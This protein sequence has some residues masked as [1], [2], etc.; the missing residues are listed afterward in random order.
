MEFLARVN[1]KYFAAINLFAAVQDVRYYLNGVFIEPHP[2]KGAIM[3]ATD[4]HRLGVIHDPDGWCSEPIIVGSISKQ[5]ISACT[6]K[7]SI[8]TLTSSLYISERGAVVNECEDKGQSVDPFSEFTTHLSKIEIID[9]KYP[10]YRR[11]LPSKEDRSSRFPCVN[12]RYLS[13]LCKTAEILTNGS[14]FDS[15]LE[16]FSSGRD[17]SLVARINYPDLCERFVGVIMPMRSDSPKSILPDWLMPAPEA[18]PEP[19][20]KPRYRHTPNGFVPVTA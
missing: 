3:V 18:A 17:T 12:Q 10:D 8:K 4:G 16:L 20:V 5:L 1:P 15:C 6:K 9:A 11:V 14:K 7:V 2:E 19:K 13:A